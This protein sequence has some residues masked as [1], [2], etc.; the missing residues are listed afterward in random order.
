MKMNVIAPSPPF[1]PVK[2]LVVSMGGRM[3]YSFKRMA[4]VILIAGHIG[5]FPMN[6]ESE[7][8]DLARLY[9]ENGDFRDDANEILMSMLEDATWTM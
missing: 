9:T 8:T 4:W 5:I 3:C 1:L 6:E 2:Q 7:F